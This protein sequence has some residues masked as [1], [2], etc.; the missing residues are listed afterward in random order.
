[1]N[2]KEFSTLINNLRKSNKDKWVFWQGVVNGKQVQ[3]KFFNTY[4][5]IYRIDSKNYATGLMD[6]SVTKFNDDLIGPL[7]S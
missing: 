3:V 7:S 2:S 5:Q 4:L 1:M 6:I